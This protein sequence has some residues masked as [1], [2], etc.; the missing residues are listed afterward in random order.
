MWNPQWRPQSLLH[1]HVTLH[2]YLYFYCRLHD[3]GRTIYYCHKCSYSTM[4]KS[5]LADHNRRHHTAV[6]SNSSVTEFRWVFEGRDEMLSVNCYADYTMAMKMQTKQKLTMPGPSSILTDHPLIQCE[7]LTIRLIR[8]YSSC[9]KCFRSPWYCL[10]EKNSW[11]S[12]G[13]M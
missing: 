9:L 6:N 12:A 10:F 7:A 8:T 5:N 13:D 11:I 3:K 1:M 2:W 4:Y